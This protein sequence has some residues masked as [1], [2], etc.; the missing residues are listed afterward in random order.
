MRYTNIRGKRKPTKEELLK[1]EIKHKEI[2]LQH[3]ENKTQRLKQSVEYLE[4]MNDKLKQNRYLNINVFDGNYGIDQTIELRTDLPDICVRTTRHHL[5]MIRRGND[6]LHMI[7]K[8]LRDQALP[9]LIQKIRDD[10]N[11]SLTEALSRVR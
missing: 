11:V 4:A 1:L 5:D 2:G 9:E 3:Y 6:E 8:K 7:V 10:F